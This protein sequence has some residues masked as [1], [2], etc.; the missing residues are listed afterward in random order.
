MKFPKLEMMK[1]LFGRPEPSGAF[2]EAV[3]EYARFKVDKGGADPLG[4][5][6]S[7]VVL[8]IKDLEAERKD[9]G[10]PPIRPK[11]ED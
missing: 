7:E 5:L 10:K 3:K 4:E 8:S 11:V 6:E 2:G 9:M 1:Y